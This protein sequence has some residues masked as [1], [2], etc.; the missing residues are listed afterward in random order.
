[1]FKKVWR[2]EKIVRQ[3]LEIL[4]KLGKLCRYSGEFWK[5]I[6]IYWK[7]FYRIY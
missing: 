5:E 4:E 2:A 1:M 7:T 3:I 6:E